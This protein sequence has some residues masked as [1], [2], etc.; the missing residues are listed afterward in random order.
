MASTVYTTQTVTVECVRR[1]HAARVQWL[2]VA[3]V[4][5]V[6]VL[7]LVAIR[8]MRSITASAHT[9]LAEEVAVIQPPRL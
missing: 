6:L 9:N 1:L 7:A 8:L 5:P 4:A 3:P 2:N